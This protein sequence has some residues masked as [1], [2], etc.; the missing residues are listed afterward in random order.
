MANTPIRRC[1][2]Y[3]RKSTD[4]GLEQHYNSLHVQREACNAH[5]S[6]LRSTASPAELQFVRRTPNR[7]SKFVGLTAR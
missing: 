5:A 6:S 1:T 7:E 2:I 4:E 3:T